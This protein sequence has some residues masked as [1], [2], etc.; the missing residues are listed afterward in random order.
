MSINKNLIPS[1]IRAQGDVFAGSQSAARKAA[2]SVN[3]SPP[4]GPEISGN[5]AG[6]FYHYHARKRVGTGNGGGHLFFIK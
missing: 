3:D 5:S 4:V 1:Y 2:I 6:Y